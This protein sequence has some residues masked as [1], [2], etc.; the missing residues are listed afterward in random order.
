MTTTK[1]LS[2]LVTKETVYKDQ[3]WKVMRGLEICGMD[4]NNVVF[5]G[6]SGKLGRCHLVLN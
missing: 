5:I 3:R 1:T 6:D 2:T 4:V